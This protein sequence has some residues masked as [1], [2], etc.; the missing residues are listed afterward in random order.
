MYQ[1]SVYRIMI[2]APS[3]IQE[4]IVV[5]KRKVYEWNSIHSE[6]EMITLLPTHWSTNSFPITGR[7]PQDCIDE[8]VTDKSDMLV[9]I[10]GCRIGTQTGEFESGSVQEIEEH[11]KAHKP[12]L[13][14]F[15]NTVDISK[16]DLDQFAKLKE[17][18]EKI[19]SSALYEEYLTIKEFEEK[20]NRHLQQAVNHY[21]ITS[22]RQPIYAPYEWIDKHNSNKSQLS[23]FDIERLTTWA[24]SNQESA[25][26]AYVEGGGAIYF[27]GKQYESKNGRERAEWADFF[28]RLEKIGFVE[29]EYD[30]NGKPIYKLKKAAY[31]FV[32]TLNTE[33]INN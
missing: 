17:Y 24:H 21:F 14:Y 15:S 4:E 22:N 26:I 12:V 19:K 6:K 20:F 33:T 25:F 23:P 11:I 31:D 16:I 28:E 9:C 8:H 27:I 2:A 1:A 18:K 29:E 7:N 3:D 5:I 10:F 13:I 32:D 30:T